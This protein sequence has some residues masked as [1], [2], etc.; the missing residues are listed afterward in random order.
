MG[1]S[2]EASGSL[3]EPKEQGAVTSVAMVHIRFRQVQGFL[4]LN[5]CLGFTRCSSPLG[6]LVISYEPLGSA[7]LISGCCLPAERNSADTNIDQGQKIRLRNLKKNL[8]FGDFPF[9]IDHQAEIFIWRPFTLWQ[10][11]DPRSVY[12]S[13][14][15]KLKV[16]V[17]LALPSFAIC[18][19]I[20]IVEKA[21]NRCL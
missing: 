20:H 17:T 4:V 21:A 14:T 10:V 3:S 2:S 11:G 18:T 7:Q 9:G 5:G 19:E 1:Y 8:T 16:L 15:K 12:E 6:Q 13:L